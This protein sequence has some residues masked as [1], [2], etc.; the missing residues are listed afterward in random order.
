MRWCMSTRAG[1]VL[2]VVLTASC[3]VPTVAD[4]SAAVEP[5]PDLPPVVLTEPAPAVIVD[6]T[7]DLGRD[8]TIALGDS[9]FGVAVAPVG[10]D[11]VTAFGSWTV[12]PA[13]STAKVPLALAAQSGTTPSD[14]AVLA[15][16]QS[17]NASAD[18]LWQSLGGSDAAATSVEAVLASAGDDATDVPSTRLR[19]GF[20]V[21]GQTQ[22]TLDR[23]A[24]FGA[25][26]PCLDGT[27]G[28]LEAMGDVVGDQRWGLGELDSARFKGGWGPDESGGYLV[29][30]FGLLTGPRGTTAVALAAAPGSGL[31]ADGTDMLTA[32][33][34]V[35]GRHRDALPAGDCSAPPD[36]DRPPVAP[37][38]AEG[39]QP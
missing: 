18:R 2:L 38:P 4:R 3:T 24:R 7:A 13:W 11:D 34:R 23:Q 27:G 25:H 5:T 19:S 17:D 10:S 29:R 12:G 39:D 21:V 14:D 6:W 16:T 33:A 26:L 32:A 31:F 28:V 37:I 36:L 30:Q 9:A 8:L 1:V 15:I 20:S 22:W 35:L